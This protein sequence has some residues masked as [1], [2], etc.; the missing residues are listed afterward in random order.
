MTAILALLAGCTVGPRYARPH[1]DTPAA[2]KE[3][4]PQ[5]SE[6]KESWK[7]AVP[8]DGAIRG[9]WWEAFHD[10]VLNTLEERVDISNQNIAVAS[11]SFTAARALVREAK[12]QYFPTLAA[13]ASI[14]RSQPSSAQYGT[15]LGTLG[16]AFGHTVTLGAATDFSLPAQASWEPDL[17]GRVRQAV[18]TNSAAAQ[19]SAADLENVRLS[20]HA[21]LA[22]DYYDLRGQDTL[23]RLL[24]ATTAAYREALDL[25]RTQYQAGL[26]NDEAV[27]SAETQLESAEAQAAN[28]GVLRAQCE[29]TIALLVGQAPSTFSISAED[30]KANPPEIP[31]GVPSLLLERRPDIAAAERQMVQANAQIGAAKTAF[32]P[33]FLLSAS[34]GFGSTSFS[35]WLTWPSR[36]WSLGPSIT[37]TFFDAGLRRAT[38][39]EHQANYDQA[40][41][42][43]RQT[44][45]TAFQ[46]VEDNL[47]ALRVLSED[48]EKQTAAAQSAERN[49][50]TAMT[51]YQAGLDPYL[52]VISAQT[53]LLGTR[54]VQVSFQVQQMEASVRLIEALGGGWDTSQIPTAKQLGAKS[55]QISSADNR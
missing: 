40:V 29:H 10:P 2:Y 39:Q 5:Q 13:G 20:A 11:A 12:S 42:T 53:V 31:A 9:K 48:I 54:Q 16:H 28:V 25:V 8:S 22:I 27:A 34:G 46:Q 4:A 32:F 52:N 47:A 23:K 36:F 49:L 18:R 21:E 35:D 6:S 44:V 3:L 55:V 43:Y 37:E 41:A 7:E 26:A 14:T 17:W 19:I 24:D 45:L 30:L 38:V 51:R 33:S 1:V 15:L 50:R